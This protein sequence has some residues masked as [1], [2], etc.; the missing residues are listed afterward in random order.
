MGSMGAST[1]MQDVTIGQIAA[2]LAIIVGIITGVELLF[3][4]LKNGATEWLT[5]ALEPTNKKLDNLDAKIGDVDMSQCKN[6][7]VR[8]LADVEQDKVIDEVEKERFYETYEHY[9]K[10]GGNSYIHDKVEHLK[11]SGKL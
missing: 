7:L 3:K 9:T 10:L 8:F 5:K 4:K 6:F 2:A 1:L 11:K